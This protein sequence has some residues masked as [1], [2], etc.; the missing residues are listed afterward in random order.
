MQKNEVTREQLLPVMRRPETRIAF[1]IRTAIDKMVCIGAMLVRRWRRWAA[2]DLSELKEEHLE[3][4]ASL[5]SVGLWNWDAATDTVWASKNARII[6]GLGED[7]PL[8]REALLARIHPADAASGFQAIQTAANTGDT[9]KMQLR[10]LGSADEIRWIAIQARSNRD[11]NGKVRRVAGCLV[12]DSPYKRA[13]AQLLQQR[14]QLTHLTRVAMLGELSGGLAH[15]LHQPL[16]SILCN[17]QAAK[18]LLAKGP[19]QVTQLREILDDV[20]TDDKRAGQIIQSLRALLMRGDA[21]A[22]RVEAGDLIR[23]VL[24]IVRGT[25]IECHVQ[26]VTRIDKDVPVL[27]GVRVELEQVLLNLILNACEAMSTNAQKDRQ[28]DITAMRDPDHDAVRIS[29]LDRGPGIEADKLERVFDPFFTT[30]QSG[31]GLGLA[32]CHSIIVAHKGELWAENR[33][34]QGAAFHFTV[35]IAALEE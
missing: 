27:R 10:V 8:A 23:D 17:A 4:I 3:L 30:K 14:Q 22:Q 32:I 29:V 15:E 20:I 26:L 35:P 12:D 16:T 34:G 9:I 18:H 33:A 7:V 19:M 11:A 28:M 24:N 21:H 1:D 13:E 6:L 5:S 25:L 2:G 31:L